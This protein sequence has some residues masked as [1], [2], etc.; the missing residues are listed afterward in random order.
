M[1]RSDVKLDYSRYLMAKHVYR[2]LK[3][4]LIHMF[5]QKSNFLLELITLHP[6]FDPM[7]DPPQPSLPRAV[8]WRD[9]VA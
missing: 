2:E 9:C 8:H 5:L 6:K 7:T 4:A 1:P 3:V